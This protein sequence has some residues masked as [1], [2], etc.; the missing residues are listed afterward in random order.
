[1]VQRRKVTAQG[2]LVSGRARIQSRSVSFQTHALSTVAAH[3]STHLHS[4]TSR[5]LRSLQHLCLSAQGILSMEGPLVI[6]EREICPLH[7][8]YKKGRTDP[9]HLLFHKAEPCQVESGNETVPTAAYQLL[10]S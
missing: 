7:A 2:D 8:S 9:F 4:N 1:M 10:Q 5:V 6:G 3:H